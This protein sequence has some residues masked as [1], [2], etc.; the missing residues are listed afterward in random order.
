[1]AG[2]RC[3]VPP[4]RGHETVMQLLLDRGAAI[5]AKDHSGLTA[6]LCATYQGHKAIV[7][8][9]LDRGAAIEAK[10]Q[11][12]SDG[13]VAGRRVKGMMP[14]Y[15]SYSTGALPSRR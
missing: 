7:Q 13:A 10:D 8:L 11:D 14:S 9:L 2:R 15:S 6:L 1:M 4:F 5:E 3:F 12:G